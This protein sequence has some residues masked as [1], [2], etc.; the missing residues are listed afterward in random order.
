[1]PIEFDLIADYFPESISDEKV[2]DAYS[3]LQSWFAIKFPDLDTRPGSVFGDSFVLPAATYLAGTEMGMDAFAL[4][5]DL[6]SVAQ[7]N[8]GRCDFVSLFLKTLGA[9][10]N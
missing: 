7:G 9:V 3:R 4:D 2:L 1:M 8:I 10:D 6:E 5:L